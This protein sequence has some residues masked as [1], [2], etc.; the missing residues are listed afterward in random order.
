[1]TNREAARLFGTSEQNYSQ[2]RNRHFPKHKPKQRREKKKDV[3]QAREKDKPSLVIRLDGS[4]SNL[5]WGSAA[6]KA[7]LQNLTST[8]INEPLEIQDQISLAKTLLQLLMFQFKEKDLIPEY[9]EEEIRLDKEQEER[10]VKRILEDHD[11]WCHYRRAD[12]EAKDKQQS[13][14]RLLPEQ[15]SRMGG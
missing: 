3:S 4:E 11:E 2:W 14:F 1:M 7:S 12:L 10:I 15:S 6:W 9:E 13:K 8:L 5:E